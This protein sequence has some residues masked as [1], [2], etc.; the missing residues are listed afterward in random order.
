M[1][2]LLFLDIYDEMMRVE[3]EKKRRTELI[4]DYAEE[5]NTTGKKDYAFWGSLKII[6]FTKNIKTI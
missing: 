3:E 4:K 1:L 5:I 6:K 2:K